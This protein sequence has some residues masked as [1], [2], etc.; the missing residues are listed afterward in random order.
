M[1]ATLKRIESQRQVLFQTRDGYLGLSRPGIREGD[2]VCVLKGCTIPMI[3][4]REGEY[5]VNVG[6]AN[7]VGPMNDE[8]RELVEAGK[9]TPERF[10]IR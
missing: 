5:Y 10:E 1:T 2:M 8:A 4:R 9:V 7:V 3:L 6:H